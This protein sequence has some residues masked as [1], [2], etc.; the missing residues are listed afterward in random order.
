MLSDQIR[1]DQSLSRVPLFVTPWMAARQASLSIT[2]SRSSPKL[3]SIGGLLLAT[4]SLKCL[5]VCYCVHVLLYVLVS[6]CVIVCVFSRAQITFLN[7]HSFCSRLREVV[8]PGLALEQSDLP[9]A[10]STFN[11]EKCPKCPPIGLH[12]VPLLSPI[13]SAEFHF[14]KPVSPWEIFCGSGDV[15]VFRES[16]L[17]LL[18]VAPCVKTGAVIFLTGTIAEVKEEHGASWGMLGSGQSVPS[19]IR[20][21]SLPSLVKFPHHCLSPLSPGNVPAHCFPLGL[22]CDELR[23]LFSPASY[24]SSYQ[25]PLRHSI[26]FLV[27]GYA[28]CSVPCLCTRCSLLLGCRSHF[29]H[30]VNSYSFIKTQLKCTFPV[31]PSPTSGFPYPRP[32]STKCALQAHH[33]PGTVMCW[34][35]S[36]DAGPASWIMQGRGFLE[37]VCWA[38]S[39]M[40]FVMKTKEASCNS[41]KYKNSP[42]CFLHVLF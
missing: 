12:S 9:C 29:V 22:L 1:L 17:T 4:G 24:D 21:R 13:P 20:S 32:S 28:T 31:C 34:G 5:Y 8:A 42:P 39:S 40:Q 19:E 41:K 11:L 6:I 16:V 10:W 18:G 36:S 38:P 3:M 2:N 26:L 14:S 37:D 7:K 33:V 15:W 25:W 35:H 23:G 30:L 27:P